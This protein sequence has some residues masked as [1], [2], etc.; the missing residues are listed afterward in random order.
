MSWRGRSRASSCALLLHRVVRQRELIVGAFTGHSRKL[1]FLLFYKH[2]TREFI[3]YEI[4]QLC[5]QCYCLLERSSRVTIIKRPKRAFNEVKNI[6]LFLRAASSQKRLGIEKS[7][8]SI[9]LFLG[10]KSSFKFHC[11]R[12]CCTIASGLVSQGKLFENLIESAA[13]KV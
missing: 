8:H 7:R 11:A 4:I 2:A 12:K 1:K 3:C 6:L 10:T 13:V 9:I 5:L